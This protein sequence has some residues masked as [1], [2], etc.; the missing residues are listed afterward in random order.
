MFRRCLSV[1]A[2]LFALSPLA[3]WAADPNAAIRVAD[4]PGTI[5]VACVG[6]SIT[7]GV[8][9]AA[10]QA[11][12]DQLGKMLGQPWEVRNFG[13]SGAT[14]LKHGDLPYQKQAAFRAALKYQPQVVIVMLGTNDSKPQN[15][16]LEKQFVADYQDL[17]RQFAKL[18]SKP[19]IFL[20]RPVPVP[21]P[22]N[23][24]INEPVVRKEMPLIDK[25]AKEEHVNVIDMHAALQ[26]H[27][28]MFPD[29][30]HPNTAGAAVMAK[31]AYTTLTGK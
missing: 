4:Y 8:G 12:P 14:L 16:R 26:D 21:A 5:R 13:V 18:P 19:R 1:Y 20:C 2:I 29:H 31:T 17:V 24:G 27:A 3:V 22:G 6:D 28:E 30:V 7:A 23:W 25:I 15:W 10:G 11:Y 9:A